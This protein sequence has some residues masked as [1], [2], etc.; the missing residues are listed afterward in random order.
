MSQGI[1]PRPISKKDTKD[2]TANSATILGVHPSSAAMI[3]SVD[4]NMPPALHSSRV[5]RAVVSISLSATHYS[6]I[7]TYSL[8]LLLMTVKE[9]YIYRGH[10]IDEC[11]ESGAHQRISD[12]SYTIID[13]LPNI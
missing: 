8:H 9:A 6:N 3:S 2:M 10:N 1:G 5:R 7:H 13:P 12:D 4:S 11:S